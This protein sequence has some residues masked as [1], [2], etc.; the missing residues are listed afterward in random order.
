MAISKSTI[1][2]ILVYAAILALVSFALEWLQFQFFLK[3]YPVETY[4]ILIAAAFTLLGIWLGTRLT[5]RKRAP[6]F[7][8]NEAAMKSLGI[9]KREIEVLEALFQA[10]SMENHA[11]APSSDGQIRPWRQRCGRFIAFFIFS[12]SHISFRSRKRDRQTV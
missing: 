7:E 8:R 3:S 11:G 12:T 10:G 4:V 5:S 1:L 2:T 9:S 6:G